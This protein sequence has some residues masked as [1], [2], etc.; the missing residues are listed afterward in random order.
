MEKLW[1][2]IVIAVLIF[3]VF[4]ITATTACA[5]QST[6]TDAEGNAC[7]GD[8]KSRKQTEQS[9][10]SDAKKNA[11]DKTATYIRSETKV[12]DFVLQ[13]DIVEAYQNATVKV[14]QTI[15][16]NWYKDPVSGDCCRTRIKAEVIPDEKAMEKAAK[17][18]AVM[19]NPAAPLKIQL[20]TDKQAYQQGEKV[21]IYL[22]GNKPFYARVLYHD[23]AGRHIQ[24]L[25]NPFRHD[26]YFNGGVIYEIPTGSDHFDLEVTPPFGQ[27]NIVM[28]A[29]TSPLGDIS[30]ETQGDVYR[31]VSAPKDL[32]LLT[33]GLKI[34]NKDH[35]KQVATSE[36]SEE[37]LSISTGK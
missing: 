17:A 33:R 4:P 16:K 1:Q 9:A 18:K 8:D 11:V 10:L 13:K 31:V 35:Q 29:G 5:F 21:R 36:F 27:E 3:S 32:P 6:I 23:A 24:L 22:K 14:I 2:T 12:E 26:N 15:E 19:D 37:K 20:W 7:M 34:Q 28:Y 25:P 30:L